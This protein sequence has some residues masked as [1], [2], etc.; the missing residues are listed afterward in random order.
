MKVAFIQMGPV[1]EELS[2]PFMS[3]VAISSEQTHIFLHPGSLRSKG[4]VFAFSSQDKGSGKVFVNY[5]NLIRSEVRRTALLSW[6][7]KNHINHVIFLTLQDVWS[8]SYATRLAQEGIVCAGVIHNPMKL[9]NIDVCNFWCNPAF[10]VQ[11]F[12]LA[13]HV[14][15]A[16]SISYGFNAK[17]IESVFNP[18]DLHSGAVNYSQSDQPLTISEVKNLVVLGGISY[19]SRDYATLIS[20]LLNR[21]SQFSGRIRIAFAGG[22]RDRSRLIQDIDEHGLSN[23]CFFAEVDRDSGRV[24]YAAYYQYL[25]SASAVLVLDGSGYS[26]SKITSAI[27]SAISFGKPVIT[28]DPIAFTY[29]ADESNQCWSGL[30]IEAALLAYIQASSMQI[31]LKAKAVA[32]V[33]SKTIVNNQLA[34]HQFL[35]CKS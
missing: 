32:D 14:K 23:I 11:P 13:N 18:S 25:S 28:T 15:D 3:A 5:V 19:S 6:L 2:A 12:V 35:K 16:I 7:K 24:D 27:P 10:D 31:D 26:N 9:K 17:V 29:F 8:T 4:N 20:A 30:T 34:M 1:H 21:R 33:R 22:G